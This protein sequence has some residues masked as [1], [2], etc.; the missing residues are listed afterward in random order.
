MADEIRLTVNVRMGNAAMLTP[1]DA[2]RALRRIA[3]RLTGGDVSGVYETILDD[4][5]NDVGRWK[6]GYADRPGYDPPEETP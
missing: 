6:L 1:D 4:T 3:D 5:G 2:A